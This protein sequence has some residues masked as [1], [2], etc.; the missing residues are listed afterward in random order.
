MLEHAHV[1]PVRLSQ[2][3]LPQSRAEVPCLGFWDSSA[4]GTLVP[5]LHVPHEPLRR[6]INELCLPC[7]RVLSQASRHPSAAAAAAAVAGQ[8]RQLPKQLLQASGSGIDHLDPPCS[9][10]EPESRAEGQKT[11]RQRTGGGDW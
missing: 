7:R 3:R 8:C 10:Q 1:W 4:W 2:E 6:S 11:G 5:K 9:P